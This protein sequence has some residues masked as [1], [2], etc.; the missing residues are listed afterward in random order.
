VAA[1]LPG[2]VA[3]Q[4]RVSLTTQP[5][6]HSPSD[7]CIF[8][9]YTR[10]PPPRSRS[11]AAA[12]GHRGPVGI[13]RG[14]TVAAA[15]LASATAATA[16]AKAKAIGTCEWQR[17]HISAHCCPQL[18]LRARAGIRLCSVDS[19][20]RDSRGLDVATQVAGGGTLRRRTDPTI[21]IRSWISRWASLVQDS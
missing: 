17:P 21:T 5:S 8:G 4:L 13:S 16:S 19:T 11:R 18:L 20:A 15:Q 2:L 7:L 14:H 9:L 12:R 6:A 3:V 1:A 10:T